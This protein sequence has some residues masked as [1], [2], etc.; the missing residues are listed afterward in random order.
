MNTRWVAG[1]LGAI[2][3]VWVAGLCMF[4][5]NATDYAIVGEFGKIIGSGYKPGL[6]FKLPFG[7]DEVTV[8]PTRRQLKLEF[9]FSTPGPLT[10]SI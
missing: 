3:A 7:I 9:G 10:N 1:I 4:T 8:L 2:F 5:V 6:H